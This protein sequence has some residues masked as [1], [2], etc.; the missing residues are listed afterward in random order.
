MRPSSLH[1]VMFSNLL[2]HGGGRETWLNNILP[3][4]LATPDAPDVYVYFVSDANSDGEQK[5]SAYQHPR[6]SYIETRLPISRGKLTSIIRIAKFCCSVAASLRKRTNG[7]SA[8]VGI[9]TFYEGAIVALSRMLGIRRQQLVLWIRGV[10]V[11]EINHRHG[12]WS[13]RLIAGAEQVF[14]GCADK[15]IANGQDTKTFYEALLGRHVEAIPNAVDVGRFSTVTRPVFKARPICVSYIGRLSEEKGLRAYLAAIEHFIARGP[16]IGIRFEIVGDGP[17]RQ[18]AMDHAAKHS[19]I[20]QYRGAIRNED[21]P[22]YL[23]T[24]DVGVCLTYSQES[25]GGGVSNGLLELIGSG[26]LVVAWDSIIFRQVLSDDQAVLVPEGDVRILA[27]AF[28]AI[29]DDQELH[30][31]KVEAS[32]NVAAGYSLGAHVEHFLTYLATA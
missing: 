23:N 21:M 19:Y 8:I 22:E 9:G 32:R 26:R 14:M 13:R 7:E 20:L 3:A 1:I 15:V 4:M 17:L 24:I 29:A 10:W 28:S 12:R 27:A 2:S 11:K 25:G 16:T 6:I 30:I 5:I 18:L 31:R